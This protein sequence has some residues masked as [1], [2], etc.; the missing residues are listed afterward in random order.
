MVFNKELLSYLIEDENCDLEYG[1]FEKI[2]KKGKMG[3]FQHTGQWGCIDTER[4]LQ[5]MNKMW[6]EGRAFWKVW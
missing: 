5:S 4:D 6:K 1:T 3:V 2:S